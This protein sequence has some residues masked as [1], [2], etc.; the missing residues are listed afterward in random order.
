MKHAAPLGEAALRRLPKAL[1][2]TTVRLPPAL[3]AE[4]EEALEVADH[5]EGISG[6]LLFRSLRKY[7]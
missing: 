7:G 5:E 2:T 4:L 3:Q 6:E 1:E